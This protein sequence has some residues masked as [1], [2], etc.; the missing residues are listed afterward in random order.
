MVAP[1]PTS[2]NSRSFPASTSV[3]APNRSVTGNGVPVP[4][5]VTLKSCAQTAHVYAAD[6]KARQANKIAKRRVMPMSPPPC[7]RW[8]ASLSG[9]RL[10]RKVARRDGKTRARRS[11]SGGFRPP[12]RRCRYLLMRA[13]GHVICGLHDALPKLFGLISKDLVLPTDELA[14]KL[15]ELLWF[16]HANHPLGEVERV[17]ERFFRQEHRALA[18]ARPLLIHAFRRRPGDHEQTLESGLALAEILLGDLA[19][20]VH[21]VGCGLHRSFGV[22][23]SEIRCTFGHGFASFNRGRTYWGLICSSVPCSR[24]GAYR[25]RLAPTFKI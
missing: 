15:S 21:A 18:K 9:N 8:K 24:V 14:L 7:V 17:Q 2:N 6:M 3:A 22:L 10:R 20:P 1:R 5:S 23:L 19:H 25:S 11:A 4:S 13:L 16:P 12:S